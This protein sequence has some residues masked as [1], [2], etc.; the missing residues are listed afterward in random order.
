MS[1]S[2]STGQIHPCRLIVADVFLF[3]FFPQSLK[4]DEEADSTKE[5]QNELFEAQGKAWLCG[6]C[7]LWSVLGCQA[8]GCQQK[9]IFWEVPSVGGLSR[10]PFFLGGVPALRFLIRPLG[11]GCWL[12]EQLVELGSQ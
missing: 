5:P 11:R 12:R 10:V 8:A 1:E 2:L 9:R 3:L 6:E 4:S 7:P